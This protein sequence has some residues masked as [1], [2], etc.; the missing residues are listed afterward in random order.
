MPILRDFERRLGS[1]VEG[2]FARA[3][4][5]GVQ[6]VELAKRVLREMDA[7][8]T[9]GV[10]ELWAPNHFEFS[11]SP[12]DAEHLGQAEQVLATELGRV[13][14][15]EAYERGWGLVGPPEFVFSADERLSKGRLRC[16]ASLV[17]GPD[18]I[19]PSAPE[20]GP[21]PEERRPPAGIEPPVPAGAGSAAI[22]LVVMEPGTPARTVRIERPSVTIGRLPECDVVLA[23]P[24]ASRRHVQLHT[25]DGRTVL[26]DL[27]STNGTLV[28]DAE[29]GR[30]EL[31]DGDRI[32]LGSTVLEFRSAG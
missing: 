4:R 29:T 3:F 13:V 26:T 23:D 18:Q 20:T 32:T 2:T 21:P 17:E 7:G 1:L 25:S 11:L 9:I 27:G 10:S 28:N 6:P 14:R 31:H 12:V 8:K 24:G 15:Q 5:G 16:V 22:S 30:A 19:A